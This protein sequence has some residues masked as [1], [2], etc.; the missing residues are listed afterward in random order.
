[1][2]FATGAAF[3]AAINALPTSLT[4]T[5]K[6]FDAFYYADKYMA[7]YSGTLSPVEHFVQLGAARGACGC[8]KSRQA[9]LRKQHPA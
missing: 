9:G 8:H 6:A 3:T 5:Y 1:M 2:Y 7:S 4:G